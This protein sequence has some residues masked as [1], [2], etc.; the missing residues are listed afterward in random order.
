[1][2]HYVTS[3][4]MIKKSVEF[5]TSYNRSKNIQID[6]APILIYQEK[7]KKI[8]HFAD[9]I[10]WIVAGG[11]FSSSRGIVLSPSL[12]SLSVIIMFKLCKS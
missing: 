1:M 12:T 4:Y 6:K 5:L 8:M 11:M 7:R 10:V 3:T 9:K 2:I